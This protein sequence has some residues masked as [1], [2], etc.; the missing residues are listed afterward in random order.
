VVLLAT[1]CVP[2]R[3]AA[4]AGAQATSGG[5]I[6]SAWGGPVRAPDAERNVREFLR[7][8]RESPEWARRSCGELLVVMPALWQDLASADPG[9]EA[10][11][12]A[13]LLQL[14][15]GRVV[16]HVLTRTDEMQRLLASPAFVALAGELAAEPRPASER[17]RALTFRLVL[18]GIDARTPVTIVQSGNLR[19]A[20]LLERGKVFWMEA[21]SGWQPSEWARRG[22]PSVERAGS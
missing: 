5:G 22:A 16:V 6:K 21:L 1:G 7:R 13:R 12:S 14:S 11:G 17:E 10:V 2:R 9:L 3:G 18:G 19:V 15:D 4:G 8:V 20:F